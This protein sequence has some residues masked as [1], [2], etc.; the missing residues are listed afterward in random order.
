MRRDNIF[1]LRPQNLCELPHVPTHSSVS[2]LLLHLLLLSDPSSHP[3]TGVS[4]HD[5]SLAQPHI[6]ALLHITISIQKIME[7][8]MHSPLMYV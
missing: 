1:I 5:M 8:E 3:R 4:Y 6:I 2:A 7:F